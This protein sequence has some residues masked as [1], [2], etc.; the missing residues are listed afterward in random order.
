MK[1]EAKRREPLEAPGFS[2]GERS[3]CESLRYRLLCQFAAAI[4]GLI[5]AAASNLMADAQGGCCE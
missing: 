3:H 2:H 1:Q 5:N 4:M